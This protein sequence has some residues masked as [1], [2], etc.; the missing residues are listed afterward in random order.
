MGTMVYKRARW[1]RSKI[2]TIMGEI[3][4]KNGYLSMM[5]GMVQGVEKSC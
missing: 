1:W 2:K 5:M 3:D 4:W